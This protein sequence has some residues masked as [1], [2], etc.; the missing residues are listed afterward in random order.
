MFL[1]CA[2]SRKLDFCPLQ[3]PS[4]KCLAISRNFLSQN[5]HSVFC[6]LFNKLLTDTLWLATVSWW[7]FLLWSLSSLPVLKEE[8]QVS[9]LI[10]LL[11]ASRSL[12]FATS[13][14]NCFTILSVKLASS[15]PLHLSHSISSSCGGWKMCTPA[16]L[17]S[18]F[19]LLQ[20][21]SCIETALWRRVLLVGCSLSSAFSS[22]HLLCNSLWQ[23]GNGRTFKEFHYSIVGL[24]Q[25]Y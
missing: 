8:E 14:V 5:L 6:S 21:F 3:S 20:K 23:N 25:I 9:H 24:C 16:T 18:P 2:H 12:N 10:T 17:P 11:S 19:F 7:Y 4:L 13:D 1:Q 22:S 15:V